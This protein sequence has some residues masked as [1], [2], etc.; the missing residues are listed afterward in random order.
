M[1]CKEP[2]RE[3]GNLLV[4]RDDEDC[5]REGVWYIHRKRK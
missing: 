3:D 4:T 1:G 5:D 2:E